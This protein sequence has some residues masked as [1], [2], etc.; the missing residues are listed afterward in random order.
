MNKISFCEDCV[1]LQSGVK[2]LKVAFPLKVVGDNY[3]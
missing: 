3:F 1:L 2:G